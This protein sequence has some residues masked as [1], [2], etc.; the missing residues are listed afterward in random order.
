MGI[1]DREPIWRKAEDLVDNTGY[2]LRNKP[3][4]ALGVL[5]RY[6]NRNIGGGIG[7]GV[8]QAAIAKIL[9]DTVGVP[10][11]SDTEIIGMEPA[12]NGVVYTVNVD[13]PTENM[14][15]ARA[16]LESGTGF[17]SILTD[18]LQVENVE[19]LKTRTLRD[20]YQVEVL[21]ED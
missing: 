3:S 16:F 21:I 13:A 19:V 5:P 20:T 17:T 18:L 9:D 10:F 1:S 12:D 4:N 7:I 2:N 11:G 8:V 15:Q 14:A 6:K